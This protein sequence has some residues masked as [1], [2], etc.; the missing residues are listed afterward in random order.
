MTINKKNNKKSRRSFLHQA[1][2]AMGVVA[3]ASAGWPLI[4]QMNPSKDVEALSKIEVD[5]NG[6]AEGKSKTVM[7]RGKPLFIKHK[8]PNK[9]P[10][11]GLR[12]ATGRPV[13]SP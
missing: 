4:D 7:W 11:D 3:V 2:G 12:T 10:P 8:V 13:S 9:I 5:L 1:S 6:I